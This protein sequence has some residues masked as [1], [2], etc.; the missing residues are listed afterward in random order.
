MFSPKLI[1]SLRVASYA[2][3][4]GCRQRRS[5]TVDLR[6]DTVTKPTAAMLRAAYECSVGDDVFGEDS[7][8]NEL[9]QRVAALAGHEAALFCASGTMAN[10]I[11]LRVHL[12]QPPHSVL[13]DA[14]AHIHRYECG[15][16]A[17][18][19]QA[20]TSALEPANGRHLTVKDVERG[21]VEDDQHNAP[22]R[23]ISLENTL[24]GTILPYDEIGRIH[25]LAR[26]KGIA[27]HLDGARLWNASVATGVSLEQYGALFDSMSLCLSKG[28]GCPV[29]SVLVGSESFIHRARWLRKLFGGGWRQAGVLA[30]MGLVALEDYAVRMAHDH[31]RA[32]QLAQTCTQFGFHLALPVDTNMVFL[33]T[34]PLSV[35]AS[36]LAEALAREDVLVMPL[37]RSTLRM[38]LHHQVLA[39]V[40]CT[41]AWATLDGAHGS[42]AAYS[43]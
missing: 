42:T 30:S 17:Y 23:V 38:V 29:G 11:G 27:M 2:L 37:D 35:D 16:I 9:E 32:A 21:L 4:A 12:T 28:M 43:L 25:A 31:A 3:Q 41:N 5:F 22:T 10:Q 6:S 20:A 15:G 34:T 24:N 14:R 18:H 8:V 19:S 7:T 39:N 26:N 36:L 13:C 40:L 33:D 1:R